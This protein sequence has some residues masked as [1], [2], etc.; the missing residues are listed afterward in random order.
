MQGSAQH[1]A[2]GQTHHIEVP[3]LPHVGMRRQGWSDEKRAD[4]DADIVHADGDGRQPKDSVRLQDAHDQSADAEDEGRQHHYANHI[5]RELLLLDGTAGRKNATDDLW[6]E[7]VDDRCK[8][9]G[10]SRCQGHDGACQTPGILWIRFSNPGIYRDEGRTQ[11]AA[12]HQHKDDFGD[13]LCRGEAVA[14]RAGAK[15]T[16]EHRHAQ[17]SQDA[18]CQEAD[19]HDQRF[20]D[21]LSI[22][23]RFARCHRRARNMFCGDSCGINGAA[24]LSYRRR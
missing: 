3:K 5:D 20:F 22:V 1:S 11:R 23:Q 13:L 2:V 24:K 17:H 7:N 9:G 4:Y 12:R 18:A 16:G 21:K 10:C 19:Q 6:R 15:L 8:Y 14:G